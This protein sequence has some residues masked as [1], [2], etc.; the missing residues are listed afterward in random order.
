MA[1]THLL[2]DLD[3]TLY[4]A[5]S[6]LAAEMYRRMTAFVGN[7]L[8]V[9]EAEAFQMRKRGF[10]SHGTT[11]RWLM[12]EHGLLDPEP[13]LQYIHPPQVEQL[14]TPNPSLAQSIGAVPLIRVIFTNS[15]EEHAQRVLSFL[16]LGKCF[17]RIFDLRYNGLEGKPKRSAYLR[18]LGD[19]G[20]E[21]KN[22]VLVDDALSYLEGFSAIGGH[23]LWMNEDG[24]G[25]PQFPTIQ[26]ADQIFSGVMGL[27]KP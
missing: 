22:A 16:G 7:Y 6:P 20:I 24:S 11:L 1:I 15:I 27:I 18:V 17:E 13:F 19:L 14:L 26:G 2:C 23:C 4:P 3:N 10:H 5:S 25:S 21:A 12:E 9:S 8:G